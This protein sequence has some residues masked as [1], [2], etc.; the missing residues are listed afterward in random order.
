MKFTDP[1]KPPV[2]RTDV[3][4]CH[5]CGTSKG[6]EDKGIYIDWIFENTH[7]SVKYKSIVWMHNVECKN[8]WAT[9]HPHIKFKEYEQGMEYQIGMILIKSDDLT[10]E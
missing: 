10:I 5:R 9:E 7:N 6:Y 8:R 1:L 3:I 4:R 2:D